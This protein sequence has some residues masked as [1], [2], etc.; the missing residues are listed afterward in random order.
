M[1]RRW[2][3]SQAKAQ[4]QV[5][6]QLPPAPQTPRWTLPDDA[7]ALHDGSEQVGLSILKHLEPAQVEWLAEARLPR[8]ALCIVAGETGTCKSLLAVE[9]AAGTSQGTGAADAALLAHAVDMPAPL[10]RARLDAAGANV[11][12][13]AVA[14]LGWPR[15]GDD[16]SLDELDRRVATLAAGMQDGRACK[17]LVI[18]NLEAW[19]GGLD[20]SPCRAR[21]HYFLVKLAEL[22]VR[23]KT[24][25]VAL[26]RLNGPAGG[27]VATRELAEFSAIAPVVWLL[28]KDAEEPGRR[29]LLSVKNSLGPQESPAAFRIEAGRVAWAPEGV[30]LSDTMLAPPSARSVAERQDR[31]CAAEWLISALS[32]G[33]VES[34]ELFRQARTCG[35]SAKTLRRAG[36]DLGLKPTKSK[37]DGPWVWGSRKS[38]C[39]SRNE[40]ERA[41]EQGAA[42]DACEGGQLVA[43]KLEVGERVARERERRLELGEVDET[44]GFSACPV[45]MR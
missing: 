22:A 18:D 17:L 15:P 21:I 6:E 32:D 10:L 36:K 9:W 38:E 13:V 40:G 44:H 37:F 31:E 39:G 4:V 24:A 19:A 14:T 25:I 41:A 30:E 42:G 28:A 20:A 7:F 33:S 12:R 8:G 27:R 45:A 1:S 23:T 34:A 3:K 16:V 29:L 2:K 26:A 5:R 35:I 11:E 43:G